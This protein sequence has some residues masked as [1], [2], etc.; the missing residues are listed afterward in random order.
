MWK[1]SCGRAAFWGMVIGLIVQPAGAADPDAPRPAAPEANKEA[2]KAFQEDA[3]RY[4][5]TAGGE[6][7][8]LNPKPLLHWGNP[9]R[10]RENGSLFVWRRNGRPEVIGSIF[11][12]QL[13]NNAWLK[14]EL[15]SLSADPVQAEYRGNISWAPQRGG[16]TMRPLPEAPPPAASDRLRLLQ[17][18][19][20]VREF[21]A[22]MTNLTDLTTELR[23]MPQPLDRYQS[24]DAGILDGAVFA[25]VSGTD[26][27]LLLIIEARARDGKPVWMYGAARSNH[28]TL[29]LRRRD[30]VVWRAEPLPGLVTAQL[31]Q[32][33]FQSEPYISYRTSSKPFVPGQSSAADE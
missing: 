15:I 3:A 2:L 29:E 26:P 28:I 17:M 31:G 21:S 18:K 27:E 16:V 1:F 19:G 7:L 14:H 33:Q 20:L 11:T 9:A 23:L 5:M 4:T 12:Y 13:G 6:R 10:T 25:F 22:K 30:D 32:M 24:P 8:T